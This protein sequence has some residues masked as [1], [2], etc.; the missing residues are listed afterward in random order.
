MLCSK[1][2]IKH[3]LDNGTFSYENDI[4]KVKNKDLPYINMV[5]IIVYDDKNK[6]IYFYDEF[7]TKVDLDIGP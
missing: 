4:V 2:E 5:N 6:P 1:E 3:L 7:N